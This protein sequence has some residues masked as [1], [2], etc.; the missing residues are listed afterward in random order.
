MKTYIDN[1]KKL[2]KL[3]LLFLIIITLIFITKNA[4]AAE[5]V[6]RVDSTTSNKIKSITGRKEYAVSYSPSLSTIDD[7]L[8][9]YVKKIYDIKND[10]LIN[11]DLP[12]DIEPGTRIG[13]VGGTKGTFNYNAT[14]QSDYA[15]VWRRL[16]VQNDLF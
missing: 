11:Q 9:Y 12:S 13:S 15:D 2:L 16:L 4:Y 5:T 6:E 3:A 8:K 14:V 7:T 1:N 10:Y